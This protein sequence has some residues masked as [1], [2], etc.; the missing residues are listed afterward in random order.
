MPNTTY[1][2][3]ILISQITFYSTVFTQRSLNNNNITNLFAFAALPNIQRLHLDHNKI[4]WI[5]WDAFGALPQ[6]RSIDLSGNQLEYSWSFRSAPKL[7]V[8]ARGTPH[9]QALDLSE[10]RLEM[11]TLQTFGGP[12]VLGVL[13][14]LRLADNRFSDNSALHEIGKLTALSVLDLS[15]NRLETLQNLNLSQLTNLRVLNLAGNQFTVVS[16]Q[17]RFAGALENL[18]LDD[19]PLRS[20]IAEEGK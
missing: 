7:N 15:A 17:L 19:N 11:L 10:N 18:W 8:S 5:D 9:L 14:V 6:L 16:Q 4:S 3:F 12:T 2:T 13:S 1:F 20:L